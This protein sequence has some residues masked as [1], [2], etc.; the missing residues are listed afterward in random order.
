MYGVYD[1]KNKVLQLGVFEKVKLTDIEDKILICLSSGNVRN[2]E[3][4]SK[5]VYQRYDEHSDN[6]IRTHMSKL[7]RKTNHDLKIKTVQGSGYRLMS[8]I[9]FRQKGSK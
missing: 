8:E 3:E 2:H 5:Y 9:Y 6:T 1:T 7:R 4:I